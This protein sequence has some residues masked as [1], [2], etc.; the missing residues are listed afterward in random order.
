MRTE[1]A[2]AR[3]LQCRDLL[4]HFFLCTQW[5]YFYSSLLA[6]FLFGLWK[7]IVQLS[8]SRN[9]SE[10]GGTRG[11]EVFLNCKKVRYQPVSQLATQSCPPTA[12]QQQPKGSLKKP[13][14]SQPTSG[15]GIPCCDPRGS[16]EVLHS[17]TRKR[18]LASWYVKMHFLWNCDSHGRIGKNEERVFR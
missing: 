1:T 17:S 8:E 14:E 10:L 9:I 15:M 16:L 12:L 2:E 4:C 7:R 13:L 18:P 5:N 11:S 3:S 6:N